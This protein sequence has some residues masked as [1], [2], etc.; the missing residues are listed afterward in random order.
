MNILPKILITG[1]AGF[2]GSAV[3][4]RCLAA[5]YHLVVV[6]N[7]SRGHRKGLPPDVAVYDVD[8][9]DV[10]ALRDVFRRERPEIVSHHAALVSVRESV[11]QPERYW[12]VNVE[13]TSSVLDAAMDVGAQ[14]FVFASSGGAI[15]GNATR[16]PL[17]EEAP[18]HP[19]SPYGKSKQAAED[20]IAASS[21]SGQKIILRYGN[22]YGP[23]QDPRSNNGVI[24]IF[25]HALLN[26][27]EPVI[28]GDGFQTRDYVYVADVANAHLAALRADHSG[29][30]NIATGQGRTLNQV[31]D[32][33]KTALGVLGVSPRRLPAHAYEVA[34]NVLDIRRAQRFLR[35][36]PQIPF[37][38]GL[39]MTLQSICQEMEE[40]GS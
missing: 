3:A 4:R 15:Y 19:I 28:F 1:G 37:Q 2:I 34:H 35:W 24:A 25:A 31:Y 14:K 11:E 9:C 40:N 26:G 6:D 38:R 36:M 5:G 33:I 10:D 17:A 29:V 7:F 22:V 12:Q 30:Y 18:C 23:G 21:F 39:A 20:L 27:G 32:Y 16:L 8:I 13:G